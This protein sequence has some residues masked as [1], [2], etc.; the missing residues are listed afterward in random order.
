MLS[1]LGFPIGGLAALSLVGAI[2][3]T[4]T[5]LVGGAITGV[6][7]GAIQSLAAPSL[8]RLA[9]I[10]ATSTG[11][12]VGLAAGATAVDFDT[13]LD[14][15]ALQGAISGAVIGGAQAVVLVRAKALGAGR[16]AVW[17]PFLAACWA[18]G[19]TITTA[20]GV[21]VER[22]YTVFGATGAIVVTALTALLPLA[23]RRRA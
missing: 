20:A 4:S 7:L 16:A 19:W 15:L 21:D 22:Q 12:S 23:L 2:D 14:A 11:L 17:P 9:W 10:V 5:A 8:P 6:V 13:S 18:L 1:F 3:S